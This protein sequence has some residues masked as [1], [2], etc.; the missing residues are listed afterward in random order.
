MSEIWNAPE[1]NLDGTMFDL[2]GREPPSWYDE[3]LSRLEEAIRKRVYPTIYA[4]L[5]QREEPFFPDTAFEVCMTAL[6]AGLN[7]RAF[8]AILD[9]SPPLERF[10]HKKS[11]S[12]EYGLVEKAASMDRADLLDLLLE[13]G[14]NVNRYRRPRYIS[15]LEAAMEGGALRCV[16]RLLREPELDVALTPR[17]LACWSLADS[18]MTMLDFCLQAA[19]PRL[20]GKDPTF[21]D[22][23]PIPDQL[24]MVHAARTGNWALVRRI[25]R[26]RGVSLKEGKRVLKHFP[27]RIPEPEGEQL[28]EENRKELTERVLT[29]DCLLAACPQLLRGWRACQLLVSYFLW[30][31]EEANL[32][33]RVLGPWI[34]RI[35]GRK[36][37]LRG[38]P[39]TVGNEAFFRTLRLWLERLPYGPI[40]AVDRHTCVHEF[41]AGETNPE[42]LE[43]VFQNCAMIQRRT[44]PQGIISNLAL[45][46]LL[47][48]TP[49]Q[50]EEQLQPGKL[51][52]GEDPEAL[53]RFCVNKE[54]PRLNRVMLLAYVKKEVD[55]E[56]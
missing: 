48:G 25:C 21:R 41:L 5:R 51:L 20:L 42:E 19:A 1:L 6:D 40:P 14:G 29:L 37:P 22:P 12:H 23:V 8:T 44:D 28:D 50:V 11:W 54:H 31:Y 43:L 16:E 35:K 17:L 36:V 56:L 46:L 27:D 49:E 7:R 4:L 9:H 47:Y 3:T 18:G 52:A 10:L 38:F 13:R 26:E 32:A 55:Y 34:Q 2:F 24:T 53:L 45:S 39:D 15:P 33:E 30:C